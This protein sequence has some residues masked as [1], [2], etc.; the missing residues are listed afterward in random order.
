MMDG[1]GQLVR[2][3]VLVEFLPDDILLPNQDHVHVERSNS[4]D[5]TFDLDLGRI[6]DGQH[7]FGWVEH[8]VFR[9]RRQ[10]GDVDG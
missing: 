4:A 9:R 6:H 7:L 3:L 10:I 1:D 2:A 5:R 8:L